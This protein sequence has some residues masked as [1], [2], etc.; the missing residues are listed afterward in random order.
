MAKKKTESKFKKY[1]EFAKKYQ[2]SAAK[3]VG[4]VLLAMFGFAVSPEFA[5]N[6]AE[7]CS[8]LTEFAQD[9]VPSESPSE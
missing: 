6:F 7:G 5:S 3:L 2:K 8:V 1:L 9:L 4:F